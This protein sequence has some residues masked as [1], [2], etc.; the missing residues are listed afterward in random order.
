MVLLFQGAPCCKVKNMTYRC[1]TQHN[2]IWQQG[3][4]YNPPP[5]P[6]G[7]IRYLNPL[8]RSHTIQSRT[9]AG[10]WGGGWW[11]KSSSALNFKDVRLCTCVWLDR[12]SCQLIGDAWLEC[13]ART[14]YAP[15]VCRSRWRSLHPLC[16]ASNLLQSQIS[17]LPSFSN[18]SLH[19]Y[20]YTMI[21]DLI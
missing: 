19:I 18:T 14:S 9:K 8:C 1:Q 4:L 21:V 12:V 2:N 6:M 10:G 20:I 13:P 7:Y 17:H 16:L 11:V 3:A 15:A 5:P